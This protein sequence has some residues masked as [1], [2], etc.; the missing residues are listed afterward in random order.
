MALGDGT[1]IEAGDPVAISSMR[2]DNIGQQYVGIYRPTARPD[3]RCRLTLIS[4]DGAGVL[5]QGHLTPAD[6]VAGA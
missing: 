6:P 1:L 3:H 2:T 5:T 4:D